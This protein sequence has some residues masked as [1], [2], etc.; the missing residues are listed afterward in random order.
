MLKTEEIVATL[1][2]CATHNCIMCPA[3][4]PPNSKCFETLAA[5]C[6]RLEELETGMSALEEL[7]LKLHENSRFKGK[8]CGEITIKDPIW[9]VH[10]PREAYREAGFAPGTHAEVMAFSGGIMLLKVVEIKA[11][12][13]HIIQFDKDIEPELVERATHKPD[14]QLRPLR[15][16]DEIKYYMGEEPKE[17]K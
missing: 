11:T 16:M 8:H 2:H 12:N 15:D 6:D 3:Y 5:A 10:I 7:T 17:E 9:S 13:G 1:R 4:S 14:A